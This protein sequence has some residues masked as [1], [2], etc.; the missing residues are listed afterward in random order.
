M[1]WATATQRPQALIASCLIVVI[2][3]RDSTLSL[4]DSPHAGHYLMT[5][6]PTDGGGQELC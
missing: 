6:D 5:L 3:L 4:L 1:T 2:A